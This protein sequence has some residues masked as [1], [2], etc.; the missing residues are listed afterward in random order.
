MQLYQISFWIND[1][2]GLYDPE[3]GC[4]DISQSS[5]GQKDILYEIFSTL[6][7]EGYDPGHIIH[8]V[9]YFS[10]SV[11]TLHRVLVAHTE[12]LRQ[13]LPVDVAHSLF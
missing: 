7:Q 9:W 3:A 8:D 10:P 13:H 6:R 2:S 5:S 1:M 4:V 12:D 11:L